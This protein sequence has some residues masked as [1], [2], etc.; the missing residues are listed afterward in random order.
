MSQRHSDVLHRFLIDGTPVRGVLVRLDESWNAIRGRCEY[1]PAV[2]KL[3]GEAMAAVALFGGHTKVEGR[4]SLH[5]KGG[6]SLRTVF[7]EYRQP[8]VLRGL[9]H[10]HDPMPAEL[11]PRQFGSD[12]LLAI[13]VEAE[14]PGQ[15]EPV[16]YQGL[17]DLDAPTL[18]QACERYFSQSEQLPTRLILLE[19]GEHVVG[20]LLQV[21]PGADS[22]D[23]LWTELGALL[24]TL[25]AQELVELPAETLLYRLFHERGVRLLAEQSLAFDCTCSRERVAQMLRGLGEDEATAALQ[26]GYATVACEFCGQAYRF[27]AIDIRT[28]FNAPMPEHDTRQ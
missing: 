13:T 15:D 1:P 17:V 3:L 7:A 12:A 9:A 24:D 20:L 11:S 26:D 23:A 16:R 27:D 6:Q 19:H 14:V 28:L 4:L 2:A 25:S 5:L 10:W 22:D 21:M 18:A 8:G